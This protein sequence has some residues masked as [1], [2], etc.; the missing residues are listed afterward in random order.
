MP[1]E[2]AFTAWMIADDVA[3]LKLPPAAICAVMLSF[4]CGKLLVVSVAMPP[5]GVLVP[6]SCRCKAPC[7]PLAVPKSL[8]EASEASRPGRRRAVGCES[9]SYK[10]LAP[11]IAKR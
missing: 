5:L 2:A 11:S 1:G 7:L 8:K 4:P 3:E 9:L 10:A 6:L